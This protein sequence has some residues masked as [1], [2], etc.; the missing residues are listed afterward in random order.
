MICLR[1]P[2]TFWYIASRLT[3]FIEAE[4]VKAR[5]ELAL[6]NN[7]DAYWADFKRV[8][9]GD[10]PK[11][12]WDRRALE[13]LGE[14]NVHIHNEF[15]AS[16]F[17]CAD[18]QA[19]LHHAP[20]KP[21]VPPPPRRS[22]HSQRKSRPP[23]NA[24]VTQSL[25]MLHRDVPKNM[26]TKNRRRHLAHTQQA[27]R[28]I[29]GYQQILARVYIGVVESGLSDVD[30][31]SVNLIKSALD[32]YI[33]TL[34]EESMVASGSTY[35]YARLSS[36]RYDFRHHTVLGPQ[37]LELA[38]ALNPKILGMHPNAQRSKI[39]LSLSTNC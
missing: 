22:T 25:T 34:L 28:C 27:G 36:L 10:L 17:K 3:M 14:F 20:Q 7:T 29:P 13:R 5:L 21:E 1:L 9:T 26:K 4:R 18:A 33:K 12:E 11:A 31:S 6:A 2:L 8:V 19:Q 37:H 32:S 16:L 24:S 30:H 15:I 39:L 23:K 38:A 35:K